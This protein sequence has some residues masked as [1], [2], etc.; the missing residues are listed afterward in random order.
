MVNGGKYTIHGSSGNACWFLEREI[1]TLLS[2]VL[3]WIFQ[4]KL[5]KHMRKSKWKTFP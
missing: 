3:G 1:V 5:E 2:K 4:A